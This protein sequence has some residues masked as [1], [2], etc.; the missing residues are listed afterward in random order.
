MNCWDWEFFETEVT[1]DTFAVTDHEPLFGPVTGFTIVRGDDLNLMLSTTSASDST[2]GA[3]ERRAGSVYFSTAEVKLESRFGSLAI[4]TGVIPRSCTT[5]A[6]FTSTPGVKKETS[7]IHSLRWIRQDA[8][9]PR[10][11]IEWVE[12]MSG[13]F[14]WPHFDDL[15]ETGE[16]RR[17]LHSSAGEVVLS[18]PIH[19][20][21]ASRSCV[22]VVIEGIELFVGVSRAN[23]QHISKPGFIL[24]RG[25][26]DEGTRS[27][28]RD[29][30]SFCLGNFLVYLGDTTFD[31]EWNPVAFNARSGHAL[32]ENSSRLSGMQP[33][34][35]GLRWEFEI[36]PE[37][38]GR[39]ASSLYRIYDAYGLQGVF[40]S[41]WHALAA[42]VHMAAAHFGSAIEALQKAFFKA[43]GSMSHNRIVED[44]GAWRELC[45]RIAACILE[46]T[47]ASTAKKILINKAQNLN[48]APQ[49]V[50]ME[51]FF[52]ALGLKI[53]ALE[54]DVWANRNRAAHGGGADSDNSLRLVRENKVLVIMMNRILLSL[55]DGGD[56]YYD[57]YNLGRPT[58][59]LA[60]PVRDD[61][62]A[63]PAQ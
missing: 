52:N 47:L 25:T 60:E 32:V 63:A 55:G 59:R 5:T 61:R 14:I 38:L 58:V 24:Y 1:T 39:M 30:L 36:T 40:W 7:S 50:I 6:T 51:R 11:I 49:S 15:D 22:H 4:A 42:P 33:A 9:E 21:S 41:Y 57:Y 23:V 20:T 10:H 19:S 45:R 17:K 27:K 56:W 3:V 37:L 44:E 54:S 46:A 35:L 53:G 13:P 28:I 29:C 18:V 16:R 34:P 43:P 31:M 48:F 12:N 62:P 26:P 8:S 2:S